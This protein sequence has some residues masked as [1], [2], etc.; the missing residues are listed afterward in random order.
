MPRHD[1]AHKSSG[2]MAFGLCYDDAGHAQVSTAFTLNG[3]LKVAARKQLAY[4]TAPTSNHTTRHLSNFSGTSV[5]LWFLPNSIGGW[6]HF[7][8]ESRGK[9][10]QASGSHV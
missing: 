3:P 4:S 10:W 6:N 8:R 7:W 5:S 1:M 2:S 9:L